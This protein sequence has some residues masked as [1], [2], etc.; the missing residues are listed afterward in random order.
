MADTL[1]LEIVTPEAKV[2]SEDVDSVRVCAAVTGCFWPSRRLPPSRSGV[3]IWAPEESVAW[4]SVVLRV[5]VAEPSPT[6]RL[7][8]C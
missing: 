8:L 4:T 6:D 7:V 2:Y 5:M 1:K 3:S